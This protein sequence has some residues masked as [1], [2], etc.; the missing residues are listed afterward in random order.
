[1]ISFSLI[2]FSQ[3]AE[4]DLRIPPLLF[5]TSA[6]ISAFLTLLLPETA[7]KPLPNTVEDCELYESKTRGIKGTAAEKIHFSSQPSTDS[8]KKDIS[9]LS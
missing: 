1:M 6:L 8:E 5:G 7:G 3:L 4:V 2:Y 9:Q